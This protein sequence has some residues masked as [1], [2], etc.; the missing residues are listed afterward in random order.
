M[1][2]E[3]TEFYCRNYIDTFSTTHIATAMACIPQ[4]MQWVSLGG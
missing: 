3:A 1:E 2:S 4:L